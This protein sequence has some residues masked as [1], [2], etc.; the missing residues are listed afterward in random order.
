MTIDVG[1][2][3][4]GHKLKVLVTACSQE[5]CLYIK[6]IHFVIVN[7]LALAQWLYCVS[8][9]TYNFMTIDVGERSNGHKLKVLVTTI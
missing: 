6:N 3:S 7:V 5:Y 2:R 1:E 9:S 8:I 4:N